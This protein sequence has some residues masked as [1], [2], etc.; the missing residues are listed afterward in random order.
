VLATA[1]AVLAGSIKQ[2]QDKQARATVWIAQKA[3]TASPMLLSQMLSAI[4]VIRVAMEI[5][6]VC[7][8][9]VHASRALQ[10]SI[11][12]RQVKHKSPRVNH[13]LSE[14]TEQTWRRQVKMVAPP[15]Q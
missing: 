13:V 1:S 4:P 7:P 8:I 11:R 9:V 3:S 2:T 6:R 14:H 12:A 10:A 15:V 5:K